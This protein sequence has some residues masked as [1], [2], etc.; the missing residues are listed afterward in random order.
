MDSIILENFRCFGARQVARLAPLTLLVGENSTG[1]TSF[2]ALI[3]ALWEV[4]IGERAPNFRETPYN[5][6]SF[7]E[8]AHERG[9]RGGHAN[10]FKVGFLDG[11]AGH[12]IRFEE[13]NT[14][15]YPV[16][17]RFQAAEGSAA[18]GSWIEVSDPVGGQGS[19]KIHVPG[20]EWVY[21]LMD[22]PLRDDIAL[23]P[24][25]FYLNDVVWPSRR[26]HT[27]TLAEGEEPGQEALEFMK[28]LLNEI[29]HVS[30]RG[31]DAVRPFASAPVRSKPLRTYDPSRPARDAE[32]E[33]T[34][35]YLADLFRS[36]DAWTSMKKRLEQ[37]GEDSGLF[38]EIRIKPFGNTGGSPFQV[39]VRKY[40]NGLKGPWRNIVD[41][42]YGVSQAL[43]IIV[44]LFRE[45][46]PPISLLQQPEVHLHPSAQAALGSLFS[47]LAGERIASNGRRVDQRSRRQ[48]VI[49]THSDYIIDR[50]RMDVRDGKTDLKPEDVSILFFERTGLDVTIHSLR[51]DEQGN[52]LG[53]PEGYRQFFFDELDRSVGF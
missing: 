49:E 35:S 51:I 11:Q 25:A 33:N 52:V 48:L 37:F 17:R 40:G 20:K 21:S 3:R 38:N 22:W 10:F 13:Q 12:E 24:L 19:M 31:F 1:K 5:L 8:V 44:D 16:T 53:A 6:G 18:A 27:I 23:M 32:G 29:M 28:G 34:P 50:V 2:L 45:D 7:R 47:S 36:K 46:M 14:A 9:A 42:G 4:A 15:P 39:Q 41:V 43:P 30:F 26:N